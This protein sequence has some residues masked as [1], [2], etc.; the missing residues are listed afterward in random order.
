ME[1]LHGDI[2]SSDKDGREIVMEI[3][4]SEGIAAVE[5]LAAG[6]FPED[7]EA[8]DLIMYWKMISTNLSM[9]PPMKHKMAK[10]M[11][12]AVMKMPGK[13]PAL[14]ANSRC[15]QDLLPLYHTLFCD[16]CTINTRHHAM[17]LEQP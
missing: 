8:A 9:I 6:M 12:D 13:A 3:G 1:T 15:V 10:Y 11:C 16:T 2:I 5:D 14:I 17:K 4:T 7:I